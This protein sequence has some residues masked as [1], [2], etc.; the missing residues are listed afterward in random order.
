M[1]RIATALARPARLCLCLFVVSTLMGCG[2][3]A[4]KDRIKIAK[5]GKKDITRGD[6]TKALR[7]MA[8]DERPTIVNKGDLEEALEEYLDRQFL[9]QL[10][11]QLE[12]EG[13][14]KGDIRVARGL[15]LQ[16]YPEFQGIFEMTSGEAMGISASDFDIMQEEAEIAVEWIE[17]ELM[18]SMALNYRINEALDA[19]TLELPKDE[20]QEAYDLRKDELRT[21]EWIDF[22][23]LRFLANVPN[24]E[25]LASDIRR[26]INEGASFEQIVSVMHKRD[27]N[28]V[29][30]S[31]FFNIPE[32][33]NFR[34]FW[35]TVSGCS[36]GDTIGPV[37]MP[38][39]QVGKA[40]GSGQ[41]EMPPAYMILQ[42]LDHRDAMIMTL[43][44]ATPQLAPPILTRLMTKILREEFG[45]EMYREKLPDPTLYR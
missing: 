19:G 25:K 39:Y 4:D 36:K 2:L 41:Q 8:D 6:F 28:L 22:M 30:R 42:I 1:R 26:K 24:A 9:N 37:F 21:P 35:S 10:A 14:I 43:E 45:V 13:K 18:R 23:A 38:P 31:E 32:Q 16:R 34:G 33:E 17:E 11:G 12:I 5:I 20:L 40:D 7:V 3:I 44:Q 15:F 27:P 29:L